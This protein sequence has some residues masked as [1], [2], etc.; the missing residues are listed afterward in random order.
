MIGGEGG[1][2]GEE[3]DGTHQTYG[4][5]DI[6]SAQ[7]DG[8]RWSSWG[9]EHLPNSSDFRRELRLVQELDGRLLAWRHQWGRLRHRREPRKCM[10]K[11]QWE[12]NRGLVYHDELISR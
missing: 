4:G 11:V 12:T 1:R 6:V 9:I 2:G 5:E 7:L 10:S 8:I 3:G